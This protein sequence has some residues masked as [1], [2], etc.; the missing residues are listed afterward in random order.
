MASAALLRGSQQWPGQEET[1]SGLSSGVGPQAEQGRSAA[2]FL[3]WHRQGV[4]AQASL[5]GQ[6]ASGG[7]LV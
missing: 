1:P 3:V 5:T 4:W 6:E 2:T 7:L